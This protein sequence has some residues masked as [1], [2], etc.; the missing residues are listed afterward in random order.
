[1]SAVPGSAQK[2]WSAAQSCGYIWMEVLIEARAGSEKK[3]EIT[4]P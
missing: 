3:I 4:H 1:M 2:L